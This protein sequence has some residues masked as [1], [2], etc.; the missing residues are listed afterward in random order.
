MKKKRMKS[1]ETECVPVN[2]LFSVCN[3][4]HSLVSLLTCDEMCGGQADLGAIVMDRA[5][6]DVLLALDGVADPL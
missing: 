5:S 3:A 4:K 2:I 1:T 6:A